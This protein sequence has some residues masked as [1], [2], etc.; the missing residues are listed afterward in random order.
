MIQT[1]SFPSPQKW[2]KHL[3]FILIYLVLFTTL[4][5]LL[6][7]GYGLDFFRLSFYKPSL[8]FSLYSLFIVGILLEICLNTQGGFVPPKTDPVNFYFVFWVL[9][10]LA[11]FGVLL[12]LSI[13]YT[14]QCIAGSLTFDEVIH[15]VGNAWFCTSCFA[16]LFFYT[17]HYTLDL[18]D[19]RRMHQEEQTVRTQSGKW[20]PVLLTQKDLQ[21]LSQKIK[22][23]YSIQ[24]ATYGHQKNQNHK[25]DPLPPASSL[26]GDLILQT[27]TLRSEPLHSEPRFSTP[28]SVLPSDPTKAASS[29][30]T[31]PSKL[32]QPKPLEAQ[33]IKSKSIDSKFVNVK[34]NSSNPIAYPHISE[35]D[36]PNAF[37]LEIDQMSDLYPEWMNTHQDQEESQSSPLQSEETPSLPNEKPLPIHQP[38]LSFDV[39]EALGTYHEESS[40]ASTESTQ[41]S[42]PHPIPPEL[43]PSQFIDD[44]TPVHKS[45]K[46][47]PRIHQSF[48]TIGVACPFN[49]DLESSDSSTQEEVKPKSL[50]DFSVTFEQSRSKKSAEIDLPDWFD[51]K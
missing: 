42:H 46:S 9:S 44:Q 45:A 34:P 38:P 25:S 33:P 48:N 10:S 36:L 18:N 4:I 21:E 17:K 5:C 2:T 35:S 24:K 16:G 15:Q 30:K 27:S 14:G 29:N 20:E 31:I 3:P 13:Y 6:Y 39:Q 22:K 26:H 50:K 49:E 12:P 32:K 11:L 43:S 28:Q 1:F 19:V 7:F 37:T 41:G 51:L 8:F 47:K 40:P 23:S